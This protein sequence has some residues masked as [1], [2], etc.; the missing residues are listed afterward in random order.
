M[1]LPEVNRDAIGH[2]SAM[3]EEQA[4]K[5]ILEVVARGTA[6]ASSPGTESQSCAF[7]HICVLPSGRWICSYRAAPQKAAV[8][9]QHS[10]FVCSDDEGK[11]WSAP[12]EAFV[13]PPIDGVP[14]QFRAMA[15]TALGGRQVLAVLYWV[16]CSQPSLP[17]FNETT[18]GLLDSRIFLARSEDDG[19]TWSKPELVDTAPYQCPTPITGPVRLLANGELALQFELNK[20]YYDPA[21]WRH[22]SVLMFSK[23]GGKSWPEHREVT[24]DPA[25]RVFHW[26]QRPNVLPDGRILD[27]FW[28][29]DRQEAVYR[30]IHARESLDHGRTW[31]EIWDTGVPGQ[32]A[33]PVALS[34]GTIGMVYV[35][36]DGP[37]QIKMRAS[38]DGGRTWPK[39]SEIV[40][41]QPRLASQS[42]DKGSMQDAWSEMAAFSLG[43]PATALA[44]NGDVVAVYYAGSS[45]DQTNI[46]W[47]RIRTTS[48]T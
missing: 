35:D 43:L 29:F 5:T 1:H 45:T 44:R 6:A 23:D 46:Q 24:G 38:R 8:T 15:M 22:A 25:N 47:V 3:K 31:S 13:P 19:D 17:F 33:P 41:E 14:G 28:T 16:D 37:P 30:N 9:S 40:L 18:E 7:P 2:S 4:S 42:V 20:T 34:D 32:P 36:R 48:S 11:S 12:V 10:I 21:P 39:D 27:L 26:D